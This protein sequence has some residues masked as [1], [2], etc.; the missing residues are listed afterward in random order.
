MLKHC[1]SDL[2]KMDVDMG[3][4]EEVQKKARWYA[5]YNKATMVQYFAQEEFHRRE[6]EVRES[7]QKL[8][9]EHRDHI[10]QW[11]AR[12]E[13]VTEVPRG[14]GS[15]FR[16]DSIIQKNIVSTEKTRRS[17]PPYSMTF[18]FR[19]WGN[20]HIDNRIP[21][22]DCQVTGMKA[23]IFVMAMPDTAQ[24]LACSLGV[25]VEDLPDVMRH[26]SRARI[27]D[28]NHLLSNVDPMDWCVENPWNKMSI[29]VV[30]GFSVRGYKK[31]RK[32]MG[33][34]TDMALVEEER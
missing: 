30:V 4:T 19:I 22:V 11:A 32:G 18:H 33:L 34:E 16:N 17:W 6:N 7:L 12:G 20:E 27:Y 24:A 5:R 2:K 26:F 21:S 13:L 10:L 31:L 23:T 15:L 9:N 14:G 3:T 28:G 8:A 25:K 1:R 29:Q